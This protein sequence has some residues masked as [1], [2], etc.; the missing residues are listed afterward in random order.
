[1]SKFVRYLWFLYIYIYIFLT[2]L[3]L[4]LIFKT[5]SAG[6]PYTYDPFSL[7]KINFT[8]LKIWICLSGVWICILER[9]QIT[10]KMHYSEIHNI[11][12]Q[13]M[14]RRCIFVCVFPDLVYSNMHHRNVPWFFLFGKYKRGFISEMHLRNLPW[15]IS[16]QYN[17]PKF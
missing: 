5:S 13:I 6:N 9:I 16:E 8:F 2:F 10:I 3:L 1:M 4:R 12:D 14:V 15:I 11:F 7:F 17:C